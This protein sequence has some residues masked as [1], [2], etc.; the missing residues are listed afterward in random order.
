MNH[1]GMR[2]APARVGAT[3]LLINNGGPLGKA[4]QRSLQQRG[5]VVLTATQLAEG[6]AIIAFTAVDLILMDVDAPR[7]ESLAPLVILSATG[8]PEDVAYAFSMGADSY[9]CKPFQLRE[10]E[11]HIQSAMRRAFLAPIPPAE[12]RQASI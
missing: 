3:L 5:H 2:P 1:M 11:H 12:S 4:L 7:R 8:G 10:V 6:L 9:I